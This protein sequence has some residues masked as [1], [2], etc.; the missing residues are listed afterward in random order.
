MTVEEKRERLIKI[1]SAVSG[2]DCLTSACPISESCA[3]CTAHFPRVASNY[4]IE[5]V[6]AHAV[7]LGTIKEE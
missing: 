5:A 3:E 7:R 4:E 6:Y 1:C 2:E